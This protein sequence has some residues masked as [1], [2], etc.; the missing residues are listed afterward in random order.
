MFLRAPTH[1]PSYAEAIRKAG[2]ADKLEL[3]DSVATGETD[4]THQLLLS[5]YQHYCKHHASRLSGEAPINPSRAQTPTLYSS[6][7]IHPVSYHNSRR[8][9]R[10]ACAPHTHDA[11]FHTIF[12]LDGRHVP[13]MSASND[14]KLT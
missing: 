13:W 5:M 3:L 8:H 7:S 4:A 2:L 11:T 10:T 14:G 1:L 12:H 6:T 9:K